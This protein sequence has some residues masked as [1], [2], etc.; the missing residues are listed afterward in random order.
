MMAPIALPQLFSAYLPSL[1]LACATGV[2]PLGH[3]CVVLFAKS[4][5]W[6]KARHFV[7]SAF[8]DLLVQSATPVVFFATGRT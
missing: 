3:G 4:D 7:F 6:Y 1:L 8:S 5:L 2:G